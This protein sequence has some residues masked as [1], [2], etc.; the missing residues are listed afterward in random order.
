[1]NLLKQLFRIATEFHLKT[2][3]QDPPRRWRVGEEYYD[4]VTFYYAHLGP[5][6]VSLHG[7]KE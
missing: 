3:W 5:V 6:T 7:Y 1:M 2:C 4:G